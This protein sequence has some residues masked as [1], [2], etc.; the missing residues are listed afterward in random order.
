M[1][2]VT[3]IAKRAVAD[4]IGMNG[5]RYDIIKHPVAVDKNNNAENENSENGTNNMFSQFLKMVYKT[6]LRLFCS[7]VSVK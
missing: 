6:H 4:K 5:P 2:P 7:I 1:R 3:K